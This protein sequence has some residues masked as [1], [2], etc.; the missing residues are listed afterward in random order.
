M[1]KYFLS[2][3]LI[4]GLIFSGYA[5]QS[6]SVY[7]LE[8]A[9]S[10]ALENN[11]SLRRSEL[12]QLT[13][14]ANLLQDKGA[15]YPALSTSSSAG[16]RWGRSINPVTNLFQTSRIGNINL[17][18]SSNATIYAGGRLSNAV[19]Q[20]KTDFE[21]GMY[22]IEAAQ[23]DITLNIINLF[24]NVV[25][26][27]EQVKIAENQ[28]STTK[29]QFER[30]TKLVNAG[31]LPFSDQ[32]DLQA[33]N[34]TNQLEVINS[35][36]ALRIAKLNLAQAMQIPFTEDFDVIEP[37]FEINE[38]LMATESPEKIYDTAL[39]IMP[40]IKAAAANVESAEYSVK[41]AKGAYLPTF[42]IGANVFS[43]Y[44]DQAFGNTD[45][46]AFGTQID[47]NLS[48]AVSLQLSI[49]IFTQFNNKSSLQ[50]ARVQKQ[51]SEVTEL[52]AKN[53]LR[54]DIES[55]FNAAIAAEQSYEASVIRVSSLQE[56]FRISQQRFDLGAI[57]SVDF[58][59]AQNNLFNAQADLLNAKYTYIFRVKVLDFYL[60]NPI[61]LN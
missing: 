31:S 37:E 34:A 19:K 52:E 21:A 36:N 45:R 10:V 8:T 44:V 33:Q 56:S 20:S 57:N 23:N 25:F 15:R 39:G 5:Q 16:Y 17:S 1:K 11:L 42:G 4:S 43:N 2:F 35:K 29:E 60:G 41:V 12:N 27:R 38:L 3:L 40:E 28:L 30:T 26:N 59:V 7:D 46:L 9:V 55:S 50:R 47:N 53:Q 32:L 58:Q 6:S 24:I 61:N 51:I 22:N 18:A 48:E 13:I 54:Q 49:P 14:E